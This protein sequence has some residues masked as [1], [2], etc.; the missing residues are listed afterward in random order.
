M[1]TILAFLH[2]MMIMV[3]SE[4]VINP[5]DVLSQLCERYHT[6]L[7][8][9]LDN[10]APIRSKSVKSPS[11]WMSPDIISARVRRRY[12]EHIWITPTT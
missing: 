10:H 3:K 1:L 11:T 8:S 5:K 7:K 6:T 9:L 12:L 4:F 2:L